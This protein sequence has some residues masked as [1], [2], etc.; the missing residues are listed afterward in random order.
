MHHVESSGA[1]TCSPALLGDACPTS[2]ERSPCMLLLLPPLL[3]LLMLL[4]LLLRGAEFWKEVPITEPYRVVLC[5]VRD[6]LW[7]TRDHYQH[8]ISTGKSE[9]DAAGILV[10][11]KDVSDC[12]GVIGRSFWA[13]LTGHGS[14]R[15]REANPG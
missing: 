2:R 10:D 14:R 13:W 5:D 1:M 15:V 12:G 8:L 4:F 7:N 3:L 9:F 11:P 6:K